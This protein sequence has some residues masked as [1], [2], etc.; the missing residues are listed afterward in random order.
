[1]K[2]TFGVFR[3]DTQQ[4]L[5]T[6]SSDNVNLEAVSVSFP[7]IHADIPAWV[8]P[9]RCKLIQ[10]AGIWH[11]VTN[12]E[13]AV[14]DAVSFGQRLLIKFAAENVIM[15]ITQDGMTT[16]VRHALSDVIQALQTGALYDAIASVRAIPQ[17]NYDAKYITAPRLLSFINN[18]EAYLGI[19]LSESL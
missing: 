9:T 19:P 10:I 4:I 8:D 16:A 5:S 2:Q 15:G 11:A 17:E 12:V 1:V 6:Y 3:A 7:V 18:V 14:A 13:Y